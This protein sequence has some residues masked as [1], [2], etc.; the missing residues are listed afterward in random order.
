MAPGASCYRILT[1]DA[2][3]NSPDC[4]TDRPAE[5]PDR[6]SVSRNE[7]HAVRV[8]RFRTWVTI[9]PVARSTGDTRTRVPARA[10]D[11]VLLSDRLRQAGELLGVDLLDFVIVTDPA[12]GFRYYSFQE[13]GVLS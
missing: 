12:E 1:P 13:S 4:F 10:G 6:L 9:A 5:T 2:T 8:P 7:S 11:P 3:L